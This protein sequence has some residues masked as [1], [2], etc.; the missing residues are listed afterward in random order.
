[1][2]GKVPEALKSWEELGVHAK[3]RNGWRIVPASIWWAICNKRNSRCF[4]SGESS[5]EKVKLN[6]IM[7]LCFW[8]NQLYSDDT[9]CIIDVSDSI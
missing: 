1:M 5:I 9:A 3:N 6:C 4:D 8:C 2:P 7:F